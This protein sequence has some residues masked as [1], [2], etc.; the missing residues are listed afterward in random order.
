MFRLIFVALLGDAKHK[1]SEKAKE[2]PM[3]MYLPLVLL[4]GISLVSALPL[5]SGFIPLPGV[6]QVDIHFIPHFDHWLVW[7]SIIAFAVGLFS[8]FFVY[9][10][11]EKDPI[12]IDLFANKFYLDEIYANIIRIGQDLVATLIYFLDEFFINCLAVGGCT[13]SAQGIGNFFRKKI[14]NG[15]LQT[16]AIFFGLGIAATLY[17]TIFN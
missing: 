8:A 11:K 16:Y 4:A 9:F 17:F 7:A 12:N 14:Q 10:N 5:F 15:N 13:R 1:H 2:V 3:I 6:A